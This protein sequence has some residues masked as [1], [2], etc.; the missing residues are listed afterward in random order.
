MTV[1]ME[2]VHT[3]KLQ[4]E[5]SSLPQDLNTWIFL[6]KGNFDLYAEM[7][8]AAKGLINFASAV[9]IPRP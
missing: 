5:R 6:V 8:D 4:S 2:T 1:S 3:A 9:L 7:A